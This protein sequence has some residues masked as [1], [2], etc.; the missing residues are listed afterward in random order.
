MP[1][2]VPTV[3]A[4]SL[5]PLGRDYFATSDPAMANWLAKNA[6]HDLQRLHVVDAWRSHVFVGQARW[7]AQGADILAIE[8]ERN[9]R[10]PV[11]ADDRQ[12]AQE[13]H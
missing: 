3:H 8:A 9:K 5:K 10:T 12:N 1:K 6:P 7:A 4:A 11:R 2:E 13:G